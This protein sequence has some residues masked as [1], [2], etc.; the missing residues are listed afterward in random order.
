MSL[1]RPGETC[2]RIV[3]ADR[4]SVLVDSAAYFA[5]FRRAARAARHAINI[6]GWD[7][8][9]RTR[10][11]P[12]AAVAD[13]DPPCLLDFLEALLARRPALHVHVLAW[14]FSPIFAL[15]R[16]WFTQVKFRG[17][18]GGRMH[19]RLDG[20]HP[21]G[22]SHHQKIVVI[23][24]EIAF[25]GG[26]DLTIRR[27][28]TSEHRDRDPRRGDVQGGTY[29]PVHDVQLAVEGAAARALGELVRARWLHATG[30]SPAQRPP[31]A[32]SGAS[33]GG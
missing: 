11:V 27:W 5:A 22:A 20:N 9:S 8:D 17:D 32:P 13:G 15:E 12:A 19:F 28:D 2:W 18:S 16:E 29:A 33:P 1:L 25:V 10:L 3:H 30:K 14:D 26:M 4:A 24:D 7:V 31:E 23:D 21:T 6:V